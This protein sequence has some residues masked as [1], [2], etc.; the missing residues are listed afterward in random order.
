MLSG[1]PTKRLTNMGA[2][3]YR[4]RGRN[5]T[6]WREGARGGETE[7]DSRFVTMAL[8][9]ALF[10]LAVAAA[11]CAPFLAAQKSEREVAGIFAVSDLNDET[12]ENSRHMRLRDCTTTCYDSVTVIPGDG[13][14]TGVA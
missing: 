4:V 13:I 3:I 11:S 6:Q 7:N 12:L 9:A 8:Y 14:I 1:N 5:L 2:L 10:F